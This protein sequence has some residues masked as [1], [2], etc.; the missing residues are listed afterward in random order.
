MYDRIH[1][2]S[3]WRHLL[4]IVTVSVSVAVNY[5]RYG[6]I[7]LR[8]FCD[9]FHRLTSSNCLL[10]YIYIITHPRKFLQGIQLVDCWD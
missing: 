8:D 2:A 9:L 7:S 6:D 3:K 4:A 5:S 1:I 10:G